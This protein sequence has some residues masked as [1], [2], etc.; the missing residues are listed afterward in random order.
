MKLQLPCSQTAACA[1]LVARCVSDVILLFLP[2]HTQDAH[3]LH[4][5]V[6]VT[7][8]TNPGLTNN[9]AV[10]SGNLETSF[11][12]VRFPLHLLLSCREQRGLLSLTDRLFVVRAL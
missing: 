1:H 8:P 4:V 3:V 10:A 5:L 6:N 7:L 11:V 2:S 12:K 9:S